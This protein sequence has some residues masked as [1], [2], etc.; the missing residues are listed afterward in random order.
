MKLQKVLNTRKGLN[1]DFIYLA[2]MTIDYV[3]GSADCIFFIYANETA[4]D[5]GASPLDKINITFDE[6][7]K[8]TFEDFEKSL[9]SKNAIKNAVVKAGSIFEG[10]TKL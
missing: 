2:H 9:K 3:R 8:P 5:N 4:F 6:T 10:A 7:T 1:G